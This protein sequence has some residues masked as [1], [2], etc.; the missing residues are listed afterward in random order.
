MFIFKILSLLTVFGAK[1]QYSEI[2]FFAGGTHFIGDVG[3]YHIHL[4]QDY[5]FGGFF[6]YNIDRHW[7][8]RGQV[9]YGRIRNADSMS[10]LDNRVNRNLSFHSPILEGSLMMRFNFLEYEPG[11]S[12][13]HTPYILG[14]GGIFSFEPRAEYQGETYELRTLGTEGQRSPA[15]NQGFY[16]EASA[17]FIFGMGYKWAIGDYTSLSVETTFRR[18]RTDYLDDVSGSYADP[19][20]IEETHGPIAAA[21]S[22]RSIIGADKSGIYRGNPQNNDW[23]IFTGLTLQFKFGDLYEKCASFVGL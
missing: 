9:N 1:A 22:D 7:A 13:W 6:Q 19:A 23:Y 8:I 10:I 21:L 5:A 12:H 2:G 4:P 15:S 17:F 18:T 16:P 3:I 11:T 14:G 20:V